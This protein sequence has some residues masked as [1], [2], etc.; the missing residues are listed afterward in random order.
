[1]KKFVLITA[2]ALAT[3]VSSY[4]QG[5]FNFA[6]S[7]GTAVWENFTSGSTFAKSSA[8]TFVTLLFSTDTSAVPLIG[9]TSTPTNSTTSVSW[10][11]V[12]ADPNFHVAQQT[13][14]NISAATRS[15]IS[16]GTSPVVLLGSMEPVL[17]KR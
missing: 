4:G 2:A 10:A 13:G 3:C 1:M 7:A 12:T 14:T 8:T 15:G 17:A 11:A 16:V 6:D 5:F 9:G